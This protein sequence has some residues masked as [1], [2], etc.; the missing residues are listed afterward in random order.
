MWL[1]VHVLSK[2]HGL[3]LVYLDKDKMTSANFA[4]P[5][6]HLSCISSDCAE[7]YWW[8]QKNGWCSK[9]PGLC[10]Y[11]VTSCILNSLVCESVSSCTY[12]NFLHGILDPLSPLSCRTLYMHECTHQCCMSRMVS[13]CRNSNDCKDDKAD[14]G[15]VPSV[16]STTPQPPL[17][18]LCV[19]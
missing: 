15:R 6:T 17:P 8:N 3:L 12:V 10:S 16:I 7:I 11:L 4:L 2:E 13:Q 9:K 19:V 1:S 5:N 14:R 18:F